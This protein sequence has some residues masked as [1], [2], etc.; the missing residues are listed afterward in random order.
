M[1]GFFP[2]ETKKE[3]NYSYDNQC[4]VRT[5]HP[6]ITTGTYVYSSAHCEPPLDREFTV[7]WSV[8]PSAA[9]RI[10]AAASVSTTDTGL[11]GFDLILT[12]DLMKVEDF[13]LNCLT[14]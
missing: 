6:L 5:A 10:P 9:T 3:K 8:Y 7:I 14:S 1:D 13:L 4:A 2:A 11:F 12:N